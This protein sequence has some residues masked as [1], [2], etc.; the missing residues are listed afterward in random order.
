M[1]KIITRIL[2]FSVI[3]TGASV[4]AKSQHYF[5]V[6]AE[7]TIKSKTSSGDQAIAIGN[8]YFDRNIKRVVY[9]IRFPEEVTWLTTDS[10]TYIIKND[11]VVSRDFSF[12]MAQFSIFNLALNNELPDFGLKNSSYSIETVE[13][14]DELVITT[15]AP[16]DDMRDEM[17]RIKVATRNKKLFGVVFLDT[18]GNPLRKQFFEDY[19][20][21]SGLAFPGKIVEIGFDDGNESYQVINFKNII[22]DELE[23]NGFYNY[24]LPFNSGK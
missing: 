3:S 4:V 17:G 15:W 8:V 5:R 14:D 22:I 20:S 1:I 2:L 16:G 7:M 18:D 12:G 19:L 10:M 24:S 6:A 21:A 11:S 23:N 9:K 13:R